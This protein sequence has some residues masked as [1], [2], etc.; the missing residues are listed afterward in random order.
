MLNLLSYFTR[1]RE[2]KI[3]FRTKPP[4]RILPMYL[5]E[6]RAV[7]STAVIGDTVIL[8]AQNK[9]DVEVIEITLQAANSVDAQ[10][11]E[12]NFAVSAVW[13]LSPLQFACLAGKIIDANHD[14]ILNLSAAISVKFEVRWLPYLKR[15][16]EPEWRKL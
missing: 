16:Y 9:Y 4:S 14:L 1:N 11:K 2:D 6:I 10:I 7:G 3:I 15:R 12:K 13:T 8:P 5:E